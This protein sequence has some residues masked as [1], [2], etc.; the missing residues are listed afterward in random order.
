[1]QGNKP[2]RGSNASLNSTEDLSAA[3]SRP[4]ASQ[5]RPPADLPAWS[6][7]PMSLTPS[8]ATS[9]NPGP[10]L[11]QPTPRL[12]Q[13][14][15]SSSNPS[16]AMGGMS[17]MGGAKMGAPGQ[18]GLSGSSAGWGS[19]SIG[20]S[21]TALAGGP[22]AGG[23][24]AGADPFGALGGSMRAQQT[25]NGGASNDP[26]S[27]SSIAPFG[28]TSSSPIPAQATSLR[29]HLRLASLSSSLSPIGCLLACKPQAGADI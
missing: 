28:G 12:A 3:F 22:T 14:T 27:S 29:H 26:F 13:P 4:A 18:S 2:S 8:S 23:M 10:Q 15:P 20:P 25:A 1:M 6:S 5:P 17:A 11:D 19:S 16:A 9:A 21:A 24:R 7:V